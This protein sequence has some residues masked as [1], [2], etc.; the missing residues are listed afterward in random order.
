MWQFH[1]GPDK[2]SM[3]KLLKREQF[4][5]SFWQKPSCDLSLVSVPVFFFQVHSMTVTSVQIF[6]IFFAPPHISIF[7]HLPFDFWPT[8]FASGPKLQTASPRSIVNQD[9]AEETKTS[10][11]QALE[12]NKKSG[13]LIWSGIYFVIGFFFWWQ[14]NLT[15]MDMT[16]YFLM[17]DSPWSQPFLASENW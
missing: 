4:K 17:G 2:C 11:G 15:F 12:R 14:P 10:R 3:R 7:S 9:E 1:P 8:F 6:F 16:F 5:S 13:I